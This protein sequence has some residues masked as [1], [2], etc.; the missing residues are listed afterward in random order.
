MSR[1]LRPM[2]F[3]KVQGHG[4]SF[5]HQVGYETP[6]GSRSLTLETRPDQ[7]AFGW[8]LS[9]SSDTGHGKEKVC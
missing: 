8:I 7:T 2:R 1:N 5:L 3:C 6:K 4:M 9:G